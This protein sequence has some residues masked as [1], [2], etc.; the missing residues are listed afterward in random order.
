MKVKQN[1]STFK[2]SDKKAFSHLA[3]P[4]FIASLGCYLSGQENIVIYF[5][6]QLA[7]S[8]FFAQTFI[9]LHECGHMNFFNS[10]VLN[11]VFG[12]IFGFLTIIPF[13]SWQQMHNLHHRWTGW[14]DK[15][16]T[17]EKT[18]EPSKSP[19]LRVVANVAWFLFIPIFYLAYKLSNYWNIAKI[20]RFLKA[21][22]Y[23]Y[24]LISI[25]IY[26]C[27]YMG[28][29]YFFWD[30]ISVLL[31][32]AFVLSLVWKELIILTQH[33][34]VEIPLSNGREVRPVAFKDQIPYTRSFY[35]FKWVEEYLLFNFNLHEAHHIYPG[36]PAYWLS[37]VELNQPKAPYYSD[38]FKQAKS[39][40]GE[41]YIFRTSKDTG[42]KF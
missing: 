33:S 19:L 38:W 42:K 4:L 31:L 2:A 5:T 22:R 14:R 29:F 11:L 36:L 26:L 32:P 35:T 27:L 20:K 16:P 25:A 3:I 40:K 30:F 15:D 34:H 13:Y 21:K 7:L 12:N 8:F 18:V 28:I 1:I 9:L 41:D 39:L 10:R 17:T 24:S 23:H 37:K 6:G